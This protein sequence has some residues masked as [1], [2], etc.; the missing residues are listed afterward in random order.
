MD[1]Q[2][3]LLLGKWT[4]VDPGNYV[5]YGVSMPEVEGAILGDFSQPVVKY[6]ECLACSRYF[7]AYLVGG[8]SDVAFHCQYCSSLFIYSSV[9]SNIFHK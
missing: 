4:R 6:R 1:E 7:Q 2:I 9:K 5:L 3:E 8:S